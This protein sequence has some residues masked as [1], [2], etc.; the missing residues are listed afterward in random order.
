MPLSLAC[1]A[2]RKI[3][4]R[5]VTG[6]DQAYNGTTAKRC[7]SKWYGSLTGETPRPPV[8]PQGE[9]YALV[10]LVDSDRCNRLDRW[11]FDDVARH[12]Q[13]GGADR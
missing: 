7:N 13:Q 10:C 6:A 11:R 9:P 1:V 5:E 2:T 12:R 8:C 3:D 4:A